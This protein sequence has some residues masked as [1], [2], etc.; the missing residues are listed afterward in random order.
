MKHSDFSA[1]KGDAKKYRLL[2]LVSDE[3]DDHRQAALHLSQHLPGEVI[4]FEGK[5]GIRNLIDELQ[6]FSMFSDHRLLI[7]KEG[8]ALVK[9]QAALELLAALPD[10]TTVLLLF[11]SLSSTTKLYKLIE[12]D[13]SLL[14]MVKQKDYQLEKSIP[15][16]IRE[17]C[18]VEGK[19]MDLNTAK[20]L[21]RQIG[22]DK[23][24]LRSEI[25]KVVTYVGNRPS[26]QI[27][28]IHAICSTFATESI[29]KLSE[30]LFE[31]D[32]AKTHRIASELIDEG[33]ALP[34]LLRQ[35][36]GQIETKLQA[37]SILESGG[38]PDE[39][40][41][42]FPYMKGWVLEQNIAAIK[43]FGVDRLRRSIS[44]LD[45]A[46]FQFKDVQVDDHVLLDL[47]LVKIQSDHYNHYPHPH[48]K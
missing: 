7:F 25:E 16:W 20:E 11:S 14:V 5:E 42:L 38:S 46:E 9:E 26:I 1:W 43:K 47:V 44:L 2:G 27:N 34:A 28:D 32:R 4:N 40:T 18:Q 12:K 48:K 15:D 30:A 10:Q 13:G 24:L 6:S 45:E 3:L 35:L 31:G 17:Q 41:A 36:R 29:W 21:L 23:Q 37:G 8:D 33:T 39:V 22:H 19:K